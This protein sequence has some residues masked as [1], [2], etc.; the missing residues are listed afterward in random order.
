MLFLKRLSLLTFLFFSTKKLCALVSANKFDPV[1]Q[2][3][4]KGLDI[5]PK[6]LNDSK[7]SFGSFHV[8]PFYQ[9]A[10]KSFAKNGKDNSGIAKPG[11]T[12]DEFFDVGVL[13]ET[14]PWNVAGI[15]YGVATSDLKAEISGTGDTHPGISGFSKALYYAPTGLV[16]SDNYSPTAQLGKGNT[17]GDLDL[18]IGSGN[19]TKEKYANYY[20]ALLNLSYDGL[21]KD[22]LEQLAQ[23]TTSATNNTYQQT[24]ERLKKYILAGQ[25]TQDGEKSDIFF[26]SGLVDLVG[27]RRFAP[28]VKK[29]GAR[30]QVSFCPIE[31]VRFSAKGGVCDLKVVPSAKEHITTG[32]ANVP[33][34]TYLLD[35]ASLYKIGSELGL[36]FSGYHVQTFED[37]TVLMDAFYPFQVKDDDGD[38]LVN[39]MPLVSVGAILP[40]SKKFE[41]AQGSTNAFYMPTGNEGHTG[42]SVSASIFLEFPETICIGVGGGGTVFN[43]KSLKSYRVPNHPLQRGIYPFTCNIKRKKGETY[44]GYVCLVAQDFIERTSFYFDYTYTGHRQDKITLEDGNTNRNKVFEKGKAKLEKESVWNTQEIASGISFCPSQALELGVGFRANV[45]GNLVPRVKTIMADARFIF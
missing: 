40:T 37:S 7:S 18:L 19:W 33:F 34:D 32:P 44:F 28:E 16:L 25:S 30:G 2:S 29:Y 41:D 11:T 35:D 24:D 3:T 31:G 12:T 27:L 10:S 1:L 15:F 38:H 17:F 22:K 14:G 23:P 5:Y 4:I 21:D 43:E 9:N 20:R 13:E 45:K 42:I 39:I 36:D 26:T 6:N 8:S